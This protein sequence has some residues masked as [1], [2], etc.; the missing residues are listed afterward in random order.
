MLARRNDNSYKTFF[1][2]IA[3]LSKLVLSIQN[4]ILR[5]MVIFLSTGHTF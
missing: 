1:R 5:R 3:D 2:S 4:L